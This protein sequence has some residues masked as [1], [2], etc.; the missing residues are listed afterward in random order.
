MRVLLINLDRSPERLA[1]FRAEAARC[2]LVFERLPAVDGGWR[3]PSRGAVDPISFPPVGRGGSPSFSATARRG[4]S[5]PTAGPL[6]GGMEDDVRLADDINDVLAA[7]EE[8]DP[9]AGIIRIETTLSR[10][11]IDDEA[12]PLVPG[13]AMHRMRSWHGGAAGYAIHRDCARALLARAERISGPLDQ[14]LFHPLS[15]VFATLR[16]S[17]VVP[18]AAVQAAILDR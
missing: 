8:M 12:V 16:I 11:V 14:W 15:P 9:D 4:T 10:V 13:R 18:G 3:T 7:I 1:E 17:Q 2:G 6:D 5:P